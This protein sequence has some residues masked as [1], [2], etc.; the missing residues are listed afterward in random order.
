MP[1]VKKTERSC[2]RNISE[3]FWKLFCFFIWRQQR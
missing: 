1:A 3:T 2:S